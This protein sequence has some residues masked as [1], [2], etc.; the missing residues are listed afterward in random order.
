MATILKGEIFSNEKD[1]VYF[2]GKDE[3]G[4]EYGIVPLESLITAKA[5]FL[6]GFFIIR[7][8]VSIVITLEGKK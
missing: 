8:G 6:N 5:Q 1:I 7:E 3:K 2:K 4:V